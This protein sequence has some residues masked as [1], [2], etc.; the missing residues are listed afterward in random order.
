MVYMLTE[1]GA[2][3]FFC[4]LRTELRCARLMK[5]LVEILKKAREEKGI[6]LEEIQQETRISMKHLRAIEAGELNKLPGDFYR[7]AFL[8]SFAARVGLDREEILD[9]YDRLQ[10]RKG[11]DAEEDQDYLPREVAAAGYSRSR[12][13]WPVCLGIILLLLLTVATAYYFQWPAALF[14]SAGNEEAAAEGMPPAFE[15]GEDTRDLDFTGRS[16]EEPAAE[17]PMTTRF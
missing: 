3:A 1:R 9:R 8:A 13:I 11:P 17:S 2:G 14:P 5:E 15:A 7:R 10:G 6:S 16:G 4:S 12:L